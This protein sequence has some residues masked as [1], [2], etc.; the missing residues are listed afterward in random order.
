MPKHRFERVKNALIDVVCIEDIDKIV[1]YC[2]AR[3]LY[4]SCE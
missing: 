3:Y 2:N 1:E 4:F